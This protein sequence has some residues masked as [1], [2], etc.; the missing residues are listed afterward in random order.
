[1]EVA[2]GAQYGLFEVEHFKPESRFGS[3]RTIYS[4][5]MWSCRACNRA[6]K[7]KW[8]TPLNDRRGERFVDPTAEALGTHLTTV[9]D[10]VQ[11]LTPA[12]EYMIDEL[13]LNSLE[14]RTRRQERASAFKLW[15]AIQ[16][17]LGSGAVGDASERALLEAEAARILEILL[18]TRDPWDPVDGCVCPALNS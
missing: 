8:P 14:H 18:G 16:S 13:N 11:A 5:L 10:E 4:N 2:S 15:Q 17:A 3:L 6:K 12:G 1:M 7:N 9:G